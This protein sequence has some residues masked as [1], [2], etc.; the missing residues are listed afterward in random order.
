M[1]SFNYRG[2]YSYLSEAYKRSRLDPDFLNSANDHESLNEKIYKKMPGV[3]Q[4]MR[5]HVQLYLTN[6]GTFYK[7]YGGVLW[8]LIPALKVVLIF[9]IKWSHRNPWICNEVYRLGSKQNHTQSQLQFT[10]YRQL[11]KRKDMWPQVSPMQT[12]SQYHL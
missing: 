5:G 4:W 6:K 1:F 9:C 11:W 7:V 12:S 8:I 2:F 10:K 3:K